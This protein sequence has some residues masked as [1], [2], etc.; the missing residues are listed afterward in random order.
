VQRVREA[1]E[2][3]EKQMQQDLLRQHRHTP[4]TGWASG[5]DGARGAQPPSAV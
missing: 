2:Q 4:E 3:F 1:R 5:E